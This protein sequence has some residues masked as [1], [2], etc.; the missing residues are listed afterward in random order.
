MNVAQRADISAYRADPF[1]ALITFFGADLTG[2]TSLSFA[3]KIDTDVPGSAIMTLTSAVDGG[4]T[5]IDT[6]ELEDGTPYS[7]I[8][9]FKAKDAF[10]A[11]FAAHPAPEPGRSAVF[12][13]DLQWVPPSGLVAPATAA[14]ETILYGTFILAGSVNA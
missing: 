14:E 5:V 8:Q 7:V 13:Y 6:A 9:L 12:S 11:A 1:Q 3:V 10:V 2:N 4:I